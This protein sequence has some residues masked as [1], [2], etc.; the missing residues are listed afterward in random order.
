MGE[1]GRTCLAVT[2]IFYG[3]DQRFVR[4]QRQACCDRVAT[5]S[6]HAVAH[7]DHDLFRRT[8]TVH[9]PMLDR[10]RLVH[11]AH[12]LGVLKFRQRRA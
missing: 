2:T 9:G 10:H 1:G 11:H 7:D 5:T 6:M 4:G 8:T 3:C 12:A